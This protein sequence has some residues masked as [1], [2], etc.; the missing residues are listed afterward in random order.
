MERT[1]CV[2]E[3]SVLVIEREY[4]STFGQHSYYLT[5]D[6]DAEKW[7]IKALNYTL[8]NTEFNEI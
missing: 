1:E 8:D 5:G 4:R 2:S 6:F 3:T 7:F